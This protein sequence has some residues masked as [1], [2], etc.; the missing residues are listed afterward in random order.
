MATTKNRHNKKRNTAFLYEALTREL[1]KSI[2]QKDEAIKTTVLTILREHFNSASALY[3]EL[4]CYKALSE[5]QKLEPWTAEKLICEIRYTHAGLDKKRLFNEK[6]KLINVINKQ[7]S[8]DVFTNF[9]PSYKSLAT[10]GQIFNKN[11]SIKNRVV[12]E[13]TLLK[14]L[15]SKGTPQEEPQDIQPIDDIVYKTFMRKFNEE[16]SGI[17]VKEQK[18]LLSK[19]IFSFSDD[20][21]V[22]KTYLNEEIGRLK[23]IVSGSLKVEEIFSDPE[24]VTKTKKVLDILEGCVTQAVDETMIKKILKIQGLTRE[25]QN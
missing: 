24:M 16:Y 6:T 18:E 2:V 25:F 8:K 1:T 11:L 3:E 21:I 10:I 9:V 22:L 15:V 4:E 23:K 12:L 7:L 20:G 19:Y 5:T 13:E 17:L 14:R